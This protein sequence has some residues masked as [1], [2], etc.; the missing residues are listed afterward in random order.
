MVESSAV[1]LSAIVV[2]DAGL[3]LMVREGGR[4]VLPAGP[5]LLGEPAGDGVVRVVA[6][7]TGVDVEVC[8]L[9][10]ITSGTGFGVCFRARPV[11]GDLAPAAVWAEPERLDELPVDGEVRARIEHVLAEP[12]ACAG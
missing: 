10:G 2:D 9:V 6:E 5:L 8:E 4:L 3:V 7:R 12:A 11:D 1:E